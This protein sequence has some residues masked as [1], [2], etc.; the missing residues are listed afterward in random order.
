MTEQ[1]GVKNYY[2]N[3]VNSDELIQQYEKLLTERG[4]FEQKMGQIRKEAF[5]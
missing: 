5:F 3:D 4:Q 2:V 1:I